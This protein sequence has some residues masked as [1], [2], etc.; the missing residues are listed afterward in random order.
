M[1]TLYVWL[2]LVV[3]L[4]SGCQKVDSAGDDV[5]SQQ[6]ETTVEAVEEFSFEEAEVVPTACY[7]FNDVE[8]QKIQYCYHGF[9]EKPEGLEVLT[10]EEQKLFEECVVL[11]PSMKAHGAVTAY[12]IRENNKYVVLELEGGYYVLYEDVK[13]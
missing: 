1:K 2:V 3:L 5:K 12:R 8:Y 11:E 9:I 4:V 10:D 6:V 13:E 7:K